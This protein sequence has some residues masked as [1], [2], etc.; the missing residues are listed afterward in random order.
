MSTPTSTLTPG[1]YVGFDSSRAVRGQPGRPH[2]M[3]VI[4]HAIAAGVAETLE[5]RQVLSAAQGERDFGRGSQLAAMIAAVKRANPA[6]ELWAIAAEEPG[7]GVAATFEL[8]ITGPATAAGTLHLLVAGLPVAVAV[9]SGDAASAIATALAAAINA[10]TDLP[11]TASAAL[12]VVTLTCRWKGVS[13]NELPVAGNYFAGQSFPAGVDASFAA[14]VEGTGSPDM[15]DV[16]AA[17]G[18]TQYDTIASAFSDAAALVDLEDELE[19]RWGPETP[20]DGHAFVGVAGN[21]ASLVSWAGSRNSP[22]LTAIGLSGESPT[23]SWE[24]AAVV[25]AVD[26]GEPDPARPRQ[27]LALTGLLP[28]A[29]ADRFTR[30]ERQLLLEAGVSTWTVDAG[31]RVCIERLV[32]TYTQNSSGSPDPSYRDVTTKRTLSYLRWSIRTRFALRFPRHKLAGDD[33][34]FA[35]G[36]PVVTPSIARAELLQ[37]AR[38]WESA[39]LIEDWTGFRDFLVVQRNADDPNRLDA[40]V[41]PDIVNQL[42]NFDATIL[43]RV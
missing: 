36:Q 40:F 2:R 25:A 43:F 1:F 31:E 15:G 17:L 4:G 18:E 12:G 27:T 32:T 37:L 21:H 26:A 38:E 13:G 22:H 28:P 8:T 7:E 9:A 20:I 6:I 23:P 41:P 3:L 42:R 19:R 14:K 5:P 34:Q 11:V 29:V 30:Q 24:W 16:I 33:A 10:R 39:A 35:A